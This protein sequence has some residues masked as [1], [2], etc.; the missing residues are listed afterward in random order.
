M[1]SCTE[2]I[3]SYSELFSYLEKNYGFAEVQKYWDY[4]FVV[5]EGGDTHL[6]RHIRKAGIRG[7]FNYWTWSLNEEAADFTMYLNEA[8]GWFM[9]C[10]HHC[11]SKGRLLS[12]EKEIGLKPYPR[13]CL[14]CNGYR[15]S[16]KLFGLEYIY[17]YVGV[18]KASC[19]LL[20]YDPRVFNGQIVV[21]ENTEI[22]DRK[23]SDNEYW[24]R[25]FHNGIN[26]GV[27]YLGENYGDEVVLDYLQTFT[28][29]FYT[30]LVNKI[31]EN[32]LSAMKEH[33]ENIYAIERASDD[34]TIDLTDDVLS[35]KVAK[36]P[37]LS[38]FKTMGYTPCKWYSWTTSVV[39][40]TIAADAGYKFTMESYNEDTGAAAYRFERA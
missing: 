37:A 6:S 1:I 14:H 26:N 12:L 31:R 35:V 27:R 17:N 36:C 38:Y 33:I 4:L 34:L 18:E 2:F 9:I 24:H 8:A 10:M 5:P 3:P 28:R 39:N 25:D 22:M 13:Y 19:S 29:N 7:C 32:G 23:A 21:N 20:I 11:P 30:R 16:A 40:E 15:H